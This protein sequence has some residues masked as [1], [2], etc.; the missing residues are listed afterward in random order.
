MQILQTIDA[1]NI[2]SFIVIHQEYLKCQQI[3]L[4]K[5]VMSLSISL[6]QKV[7]VYRRLIHGTSLVRRITEHCHSLRI[8]GMSA[9]WFVVELL[10]ESQDEYNLL[11]QW[12]FDTLL[13][14]LTNYYRTNCLILFFC[15]NGPQFQAIISSFQS[16]ISQVVLLRLC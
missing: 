7:L 10:T 3:G 13:I 15:T 12:R 6:F 2:P 8:F 16:L 9:D 14:N 11:L 5:F 4:Y 1:Q